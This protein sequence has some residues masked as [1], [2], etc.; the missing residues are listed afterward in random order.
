M[1][2]NSYLFNG[3]HSIPPEALAAAAEFLRGLRLT[4]KA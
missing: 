4:N 1:A 3:E 2:R